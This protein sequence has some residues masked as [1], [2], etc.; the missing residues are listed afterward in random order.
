M[1]AALPQPPA[2]APN[3]ERYKTLVVILTVLTTVI[4]S[5]IA[6]L[7]SDANIRGATSNRESQLYAVLAEGEIHRQGLQS[8]Y[9]TSILSTFLKDSQ[10][11]TVMQLTALEQESNGDLQAAAASQVKAAVSQARADTAMKFSI[12]YTDPR[13]APLN[14]GEN[15]NLERYVA[16]SF[17]AANEIVT[18]QNAASDAYDLWNRKSDS[19]T[20]VL[21]ILAVTLFLFGLAQALTPRLRLTFAIFGLVGLAAAGLWTLL[22]LIS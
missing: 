13:Y 16:D 3:P 22:V 18:K 20:G 15:P 12:F 6:G 10:E 4:T 17:A 5:I 2:Q 11:A 7:Q 21:T 1:S 14:P 19:Y 9:D 8:A